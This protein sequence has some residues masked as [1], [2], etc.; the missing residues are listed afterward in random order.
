MQRL[1][2]TGCVL[3]ALGFVAGGLGIALNHVW[4]LPLV[5]GTS[6]CASVLI[7]FCWDGTPHKW[8]DQG[9]IGLLINLA[10]L[11]GVFVL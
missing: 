1:A 9:G 5:A 7:L 4:W 3:A 2:S 6:I 11:L 10:I 8:A